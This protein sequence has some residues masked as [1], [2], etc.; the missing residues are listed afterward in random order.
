MKV[1]DIMTSCVTTVSPTETLATAAATMIDSDVGVL[2][3]VE[4][5]ALVGIV[6]DRDLAV[7][8]LACGLEAGAPVLRVM[9]GDVI[10]CDPDDELAEVLRDMAVQQIRRMPVCAS[11]GEL[12]GI[13]SIADAAENMEYAGEATETLTRICHSRGRHC[14]TRHSAERF[15]FETTD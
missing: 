12:V 6:T 5:G 10:C 9:T 11:T 2:P 8:G 1:R 15:L 14:Q 3:V 7:R 4:D 13:V